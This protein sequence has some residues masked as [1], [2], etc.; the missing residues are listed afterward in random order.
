MICVPW[1]DEDN[2]DTCAKMCRADN[3]TPTVAYFFYKKFCFQSFSQTVYLDLE[4]ITE[5]LREAHN[6]RNLCA[7][8]I[9]FVQCF[10]F[11]RKEFQQIYA[12]LKA[13]EETWT[14]HDKLEKMKFYS[15][16]DLQNIYRCKH[17]PNM[18]VIISNKSCLDTSSTGNWKYFVRMDILEN[19]KELIKGFV[20]LF[21][22]SPNPNKAYEISSRTEKE[23]TNFCLLIYQFSRFK[24]NDEDIKDIEKENSIKLKLPPNEVKWKIPEH[25][26]TKAV[27]EVM[28]ILIKCSFYY[29]KLLIVFP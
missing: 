14:A 16:K 26:I 3:L 22:R 18:N 6:V 11:H 20:K 23:L 21:V 8:L 13:G 27:V 17:D 4:N 2:E 25:V 12:D 5:N 15:V 10:L 19:D 7:K 9:P 29:L 1:S 28:L 24:I